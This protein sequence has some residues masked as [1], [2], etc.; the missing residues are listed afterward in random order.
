[1][2]TPQ[3]SPG[4][5]VRE[6]DLTVGR[7]DNVLDN[8]GAIAGPFI[9]GP[10]EEPTTVSNE[11]EL[12]QLFGEPSSLDGQYEY[13][14]TAS[15]YLS[16]GGILKVVRTNSDNI[17]NATSRTQLLE[18]IT[19]FSLSFDADTG[20]NTGTYIVG[21]VA[22]PTGYGYT[23][24]SLFGEGATFQ[25]GI[26]T[27]GELTSI[28]V[29]NPGAGYTVGSTLIVNDIVF[30]GNN[31]VAIAITVGSVASENNISVSGGT[32]K[33]EN[34]DSYTGQDDSTALGY[35]VA[36]KNPGTWANSLKVAMIDNFAD[37]RLIVG[38]TVASSV[39]VGYGVSTSIA[40]VRKPVRR[41]GRGDTGGG[42]FTE[43][44]YLFGIVTGKG[45]TGGDAYIDVKIVA[46]SNVVDGVTTYEGVVYKNRSRHASFKP[47]NQLTAVNSA[48]VAQTSF[49]LLTGSVIKDWYNEQFVPLDTGNV[50]WRNI[51]PKP[52]TNQYV[53][54]RL[55]RGDAIHVAVFDEFG[56]VSGVKG[57]LLE[58]FVSLSKASDAVSAVDSPT[59]IY[60][61]DYIAT[62]SK[63]IYL[64]DNPSDINNNE[65]VVAGGFQDLNTDLT[66][67]TTA[68]GLWN[69][70]ARE[71]WFSLIGP[72]TYTL[73]GGNDY[74][75]PVT[76]ESSS[77][78]IIA[79]NNQVSVS[80][81]SSVTAGSFKAT[82][83]E[84]LN[85]Y[86]YFA[87]PDREEVDYLLMGP[88][89]DDKLE[90][91]AKAENLISIARARKDCIATISPHRSDV[92][93]DGLSFFSTD[94]ITDNVV[95]FFSTLSSSSYAIFDS[96]Y[97][98]T[99]DR[100]NN[101]FRYIP[102][103]GDVAGLCVRTS[104]EAYPWFSPAGQQRGIL[105]NAVKLAY[106]PDKSQRDELYTARVNPIITQRGLGT[107]LFGD[108]TALGYPS[109]F[110]R[111]NV[112]RLF[113]TV[114]Q[115]LSRFAD[116]QLFEINDEITR[117]NF[118]NVVE[119]YL[120][121]IQSKRGLY[122]YLVV[123]DETNNTPDIIDNNEF[124]A[125]IYLKPTKS[126]N[127]VTLTF[128][129]TR[130]GVSFEEVAGTV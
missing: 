64:G 78:L 41:N 88:G 54:D 38:S 85:G 124:R 107:L 65:T 60:Y 108:K 35:Q 123:C 37:Q 45:G 3:L 87:D 95:E 97:K 102:C 31:A 28:E 75:A 1:M 77:A 20:L 36:A 96:G 73:S 128:V 86:D 69:Q 106:N 29:I 24:N 53:L 120:S 23:T 67:Y 74:V 17:V 112:R 116:A 91:Q 101:Q 122:G 21:E 10:V 56:L 82:L 46:K 109:A 127:Y 79:A 72:V 94:T 117:A 39:E 48:G 34:F 27:V 104:I 6:V 12:I 47:G 55:G 83:G 63:Y 49:S 42:F 76:S 105:N 57:N 71:T 126:I 33:I 51:A 4:V 66:P 113:L 26:G 70:T 114:E 92:V 89:L 8:I 99:Y 118:V 111:I 43:S 2:A 100:F 110:D 50:F 121:D 44:G 98:Y 5:L 11:E 103:N 119:P 7:V 129:A 90:S 15:S 40:N 61:K 52:F 30:G 18:E 125:D 19:E 59:R 84:L 115:A 130:T 25:I 62:Y 58:K 32:V 81:A 13:W 14:M 80:A 68:Q 16:Y 93:G 9:K 22:D